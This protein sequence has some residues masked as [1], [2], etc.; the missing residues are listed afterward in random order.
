[1]LLRMAHQKGFHVGM[2]YVC[3][4]LGYAPPVPITPVDEVAELQRQFI[5]AQQAMAR[6]VEQM[7]AASSR[8]GQVYMR[9]GQ[10]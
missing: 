8:V 9:A 5:E 4:R 10:P 6:M 3:E 2:T 1:M 7:Q